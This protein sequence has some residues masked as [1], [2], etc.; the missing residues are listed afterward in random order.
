M[1]GREG[2]TPSKATLNAFWRQIGPEIYMLTNDY[3]LLFIFL[4]GW[5][6]HSFLFGTFC[7]F[8]S[9]PF[10]FRVFGDL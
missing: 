5:A 2:Q 1:R 10:F 9:F 4:Q 6:P 8:R 3:A 7:S